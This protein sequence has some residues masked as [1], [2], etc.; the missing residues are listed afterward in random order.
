MVTKIALFLFACLIDINPFKKVSLL[1]CV[2]CVLSCLCVSVP[3]S[4]TLIHI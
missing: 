1:N 3:S 4:I 2:P